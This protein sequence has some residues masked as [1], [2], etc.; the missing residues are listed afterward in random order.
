MHHATTTVQHHH[1][2]SRRGGIHRTRS[3][4][5]L[6]AL[7]AATT[8]SPLL[9]QT[10]SAAPRLDWK[11]D[12]R[13][14]LDHA[15][16][17]GVYTDTG[18]SANAFYLRRVNLGA[19]VRWHPQWRAAAELEADS[20][21]DIALDSAFVGWAPRPGLQ[22]RLGRIDP[23]F[24][25]DQATS[26][27]WTLG[28]ER[29]ALWDLAPDVADSNAGV[30]LRADGHGRRWHASGGLYDKRD[31]RALVARGVWMPAVGRGTVLQLGASA[32]HS[33]DWRGNGRIRTRLG[34]RGVSEDPAGR[35][36]TLGAAA[37]LP[38][39][40]RGDTAFGLEAA[41]QHG[42][43]LLQAE[44]LQR[45]L[46]AGDGVAARTA[47]GAYVQAAWS[48]TGEAR[49]HDEERARFGRARPLD[50][51]WGAWEVFGR[52]DQLGVQGGGDATVHTVGV[53]WTAAEHWRAL[54]NL[55]HGRSDDANAAGKRSGLGLSARVQAVF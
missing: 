17:D 2:D 13:A 41:W 16:F 45:R 4:L 55:H 39:A 32:A 51:R 12:G 24:G 18:A 8:A 30:G 11:L 47:R 7:L 44:A 54:L 38:D 53:G 40:Y 37:A 15:R 6:L 3:R 26:T 27:S 5:P 34:V 25:L 22:L 19:T 21:G 48:I 28:T 46:G 14:Q 20:D 33:G 35:R 29:S 36:S 10:T 31:H 43:W 42:R 1:H 50:T 52:I 9:A 23:D 49:R